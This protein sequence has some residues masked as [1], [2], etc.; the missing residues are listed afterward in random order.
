[1]TRPPLKL[2]FEYSDTPDFRVLD[3]EPDGVRC[4]PVLGRTHLKAFPGHVTSE[5]HVHE[6]VI[7]ISYCQRGEL[8]FDSMG[9]EYPFYPGMV[10]VSRPN[11]SHHLRVFPKGLLMYWLFFRIPKG[12][13]PLLS[14]P[15]K[16][17]HW[18]TSSLMAMP[19]RLFPGGDRIRLAFQRVFGVYDAEPRGTPQR[20]LR[21]RLAVLD[22][23]VA[24]LDASAEAPE[25]KAGSKL[26]QVVEEIRADPVKPL[27][28][29]ELVSRLALSPSNLIVQFKRMTGL[30]PLAFRNACRIDLAK[31]EL[32]RGKVSIAALAGK[33][34]YSS[35]QNFAT[36]FRLATGKTPRDW[37]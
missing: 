32:K 25:T 24:V 1:M 7:E 16:E 12:N 31:R 8:V 10:F 5:E 36:Q 6:E 33:L 19:R 30:P 3:L 21:L 23:L 34:G 35:A 37:R 20:T 17:A 9:V 18:L 15:Q 27:S 22:L 2:P 26:A 11:E 14:L 13:F 29:D 4:I 28:I